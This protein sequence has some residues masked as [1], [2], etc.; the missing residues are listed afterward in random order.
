MLERAKMPTTKVGD[1][2][3]YYEIH[4]N[5]DPLVI[6]P[7][8]GSSTAYFFRQ[9]P[10]LAEEYRVIAFDN[11]GNGLSDKPDIPCSTETMAD[12]A[13]GLLDA[14]RI[15]KAHIY[16]H[17][18]GGMI[19]QHLALR[20]PEMAASLILACTS[21]GGRHVVPVD[22]EFIAN[23]FD[24]QQSPEERIRGRL[25]FV[26]SQK[27]IDNNPDIIE[28]YI[29]LYV[30]YT[31]PP[32]TYVRQAEAIVNHDTYDQLHE[33]KVPTLVITGTHGRLQPVETSRTLASRIP[34][35]E[36]IIMDGLRH[37]LYIEGAEDVNKAILS[38]LKRHPLEIR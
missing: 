25:R 2:N 19:A 37:L 11:R 9:I 17:S 27:F 8:L 28:H 29:S 6:I 3:M 12:D 20:Y 23:S 16:G 36:L 10:A 21:C 31:S 5:G 22:Q 7:G 13:A 34:N 35:A 18:M 30:K 15:R 38:F 1:I 32:H 4:G 26:F 14:L 33:I 24:T